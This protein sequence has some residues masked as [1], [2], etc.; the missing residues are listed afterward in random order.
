[1]CA[2]ASEDSIYRHEEV[3]IEVNRSKQFT[4]GNKIQS[5]EPAIIR[6]F[7]SANLGDLLSQHSQIFIKSSGPGNLATVSARGSNAHHTPVLWNAFNILS[8]TRGQLNF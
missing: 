2:Q 3:V 5:I 7:H 6:S 8:P 1:A 4:S